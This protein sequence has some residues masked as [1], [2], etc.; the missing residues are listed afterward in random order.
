MR[1]RQQY[2]HI[3]ITELYTELYT[4]LI[5]EQIAELFFQRRRIDLKV[6]SL[7]TLRCG[8]RVIKRELQGGALWVTRPPWSCE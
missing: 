8:M 6:C 4:E 7:F 2:T 5:P 1:L 3:I